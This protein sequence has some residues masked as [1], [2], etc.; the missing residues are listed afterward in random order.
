[1]NEDGV[2]F[3]GIVCAK[4]HKPLIQQAVI[5]LLSQGRAAP[6]QAGNLPTGGER[7][8]S[9]LARPADHTTGLVPTAPH[10]WVEPKDLAWLLASHIATSSSIRGRFSY[11]LAH[12]GLLLV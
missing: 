9:L 12:G 8:G 6:R 5:Q 7:R 4:T 10:W 11:R 1:M 3:D 2:V